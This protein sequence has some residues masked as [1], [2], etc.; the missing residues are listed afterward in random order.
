MSAGINEFKQFEVNKV[1]ID[2]NKYKDTQIDAS[3]DI[4]YENNNKYL[5]PITSHIAHKSF[6]KR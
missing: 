6:T 3:E 5:L 1:R 4:I 2:D